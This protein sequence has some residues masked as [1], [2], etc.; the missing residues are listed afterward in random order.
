MVHILPRSAERASPIT[1]A[2]AL[3]DLYTGRKAATNPLPQDYPNLQG[4]P[5]RLDGGESFKARRGGYGL[6]ERLSGELSR[7]LKPPPG[8]VI[9]H[10]QVRLVQHDAVEQVMP[11]GGLRRSERSPEREFP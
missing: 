6:V 11:I 1:R 4:K 7:W 8:A 2:V 3:Q 9:T 10:I 5:D